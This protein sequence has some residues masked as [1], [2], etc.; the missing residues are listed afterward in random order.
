MKLKKKVSRKELMAT[1]DEFITTTE[2]SLRFIDAHRTV[3][4]LI[5]GAVVLTFVSLLVV[6]SYLK[7]READASL[8]F[9]KAYSYFQ[10]KI[11]QQA[12]KDKTPLTIV[13]A[14]ALKQFEEVINKYERTNASK[15]AMLYAAQ[16]AYWGQQNDKA[17]SFY[18]QYLQRLD[19]KD[20]SRELAW[21]GLA[22]SYQAKGNCNK[23]LEYFQKIV[24]SNG[25]NKVYA[26]Y[27]MAQCFENLKDKEQA[28]QMRERIKKE[29]PDSTLTQ[30]IEAKF[31]AS[32]ASKQEKESERKP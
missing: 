2:R 13:Y 4:A 28:Q 15:M 18:Q 9:G 29:F 27:N 3:F 10:A 17:I 5:T 30:W 22:Y 6:R 31:G 20:P 32:A 24:D 26:Y 16:C 1:K 19:E 7:T 25:F 23:A 21:S 11:R 8:Q 12:G 14:N